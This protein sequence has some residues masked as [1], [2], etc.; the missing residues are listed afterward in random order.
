MRLFRMKIKYKQKKYKNGNNNFRPACFCMGIYRK[1]RRTAPF[2]KKEPQKKENPSLPCVSPHLGGHIILS[3]KSFLQLLSSAVYS[4]SYWISLWGER[5]LQNTD[6]KKRE[7]RFRP[8]TAQN[9][10][11]FEKYKKNYKICRFSLDPTCKIIEVETSFFHLRIKN[12]NNNK[13][14]HYGKK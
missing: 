4:L 10:F 3:T 8:L 11:L 6:I 12:I 13:K 1:Q 7:N 9:G 5:Y 14:N 2:T